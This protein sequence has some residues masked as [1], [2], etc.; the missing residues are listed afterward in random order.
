MGWSDRSGKTIDDIIAKLDA[1]LIPTD[2]SR[3]PPWP[4]PDHAARAARFNTPPMFDANGDTGLTAADVLPG[5]FEDSSLVCIGWSKYSF[6]T[7]PAAEAR[8]SAHNA[9]YI[10]P[11]VMLAEVASNGSKRNKEISSPPERRRYAVIEFDTGES[12]EQQT[13]VLSSLHHPDHPLVMAVWSAGK[14]IH[15]WYNVG[16]L[17]P[18][19]KLRFFRLAA[20]LGADE[21]LFDMSKLVRMPGGTRNG[22]KQTI[23]YW[24]PEHL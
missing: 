23:L 6:T 16:A 5:L 4:E 7:M 13:A 24:E 10:V 17:P 21:S 20:W 2:T 11:N 22:Q 15:A 19:L 3:L 14:S 1:G 12:R 9:E 18:Y 8:M